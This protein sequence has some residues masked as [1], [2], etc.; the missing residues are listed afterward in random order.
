MQRFRGPRRGAVAVMS[1]AA[2]LV[3]APAALAKP[4]APGAPGTKHTWAPADKHGFGGARQEASNAW[5]TLRQSSLS[6]VY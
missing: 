5:F 3:A 4:Q 2:L 1:A 6:E